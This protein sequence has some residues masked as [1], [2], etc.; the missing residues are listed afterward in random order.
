M[1]KRLIQVVEITLSD[2]RKGIFSGPELVTEDD[3]LLRVERTV[4]HEGHE[5]PADCKWGRV[6]KLKKGKP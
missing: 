2:G 6:G 5:L 4:F 1:S 3:V